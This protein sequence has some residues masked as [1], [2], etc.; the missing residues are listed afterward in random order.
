[1]E[2]TISIE[3]RIQEVLTN[4]PLFQVIQETPAEQHFLSEPYLLELI[5]KKYYSTPEVA[6]WFDVTD[7]QLR[8]YIKPFEEYLFDGQA[9]N[10]TTATVIRLDFKA[11]LKLRMI[12]LLKDEYRVKG[13]KQ[14]LRIN[15]DGHIIKQVPTQENLPDTT[16]DKRL[17]TLSQA[18]AQ[19]MHTGLFQ[20]EQDEETEEMK[21][22]LNEDF[23]HQKIKALPSESS[24]E[25][26]K[27]QSKTEQLEQKNQELAEKVEEILTSNKEDI[28]IRIR[29]KHIEQS[30]LNSLEN[31]ALKQYVATK[32][33]QLFGKLFRSS[34]IEIEKKQYIAAY[35]EEHF[36][37][38]LKEE[39]HQYHERLVE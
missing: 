16:H 34:H 19:I 15:E 35:I 10:P 31:E 36:S 27:L 3:K 24:Q 23:L 30:V 37:E 21:L 14:L 32:G 25:I 38:R 33:W 1:M 2:Q 6:G 5:E 39:L 26:E 12:L 17:D 29:E 20:M 7:A 11:I 28:A 18:F 22:T 8:Y 4:D 9:T 13:L